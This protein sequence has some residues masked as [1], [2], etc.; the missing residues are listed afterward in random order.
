MV[1]NPPVLFQ[2]LTIRGVTFKNRIW[3]APMCQYSASA[4]DEGPN[5]ITGALTPYHLVHLGHLALK[6]VGLT[7]IEATAVTPNGRISP[8]DS[9][10][11]RDEQIEGIRRVAEFVHA[12]GGALGIQLA[13]AGR[14]ASTVAPWLG[15]E[16]GKSVVAGEDVGGW[17][18]D[19]VGPS[20]IQWAKEG[21][22]LPREMS[23][24]EI[25]DTVTAFAESARRAVE[26][27]VDVIEVSVDIH[28]E[29]SFLDFIHPPCSHFASFWHFHRCHYDTSR[30]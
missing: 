15:R 17:P 25:E 30:R 22:Y 12:Q 7:F 26:A 16:R 29:L 9:G 11:W 27:G 19:V 6:G 10:L 18:K 20:A 1:A 24:K 2:P 5:R 28:S 23:E 14:K 13:H 3:A 21:Y 8:N 4:F